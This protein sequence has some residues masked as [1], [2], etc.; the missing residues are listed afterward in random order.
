MDA[1]IIEDEQRAANRLVRLIAEID[2][3]INVVRCIET[4]DESVD[5]LKSN[6][7]DLIFS[8]IQ[9]ADGLSFEIYKQLESIP[10]II[11]TTAYDQYAINAFQTNGIDYLLKP[12]EPVALNKAIQKLKTLTNPSIDNAIIKALSKQLGNSNKVYKDRFMVKV[13]QH[14]KSISSNQIQ[15][16][17]SLDKS[18]YLFTNERRNYNLDYSLEY[19][20][21]EL[22]PKKFFRINRKMILNIDASFEITSWSNSR[23]KITIPGMDDDLLIVARNRVKE[24]KQWLGEI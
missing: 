11:F 24:F 8:D 10:P 18:T 15:A 6:K 16:F 20:E 7:V 14:L 2:S 22:S 13:G 9:L 23:L 12:I 5:F 1:I 4:I 19:L 21:E 17:Y 3:N